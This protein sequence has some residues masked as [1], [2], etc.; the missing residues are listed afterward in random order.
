MTFR[1]PALLMAGLI[2]C[3]F[4]VAAQPLSSGD[5]IAAAF[6]GNT[7]QGSL[8]A[9]GK[10]EEFYDPSGAIRGSDYSGTWGVSGNQLCLSYDGD[11]P[12]CWSISLSGQRA[13]WIGRNGEEGSGAILKGNPRGY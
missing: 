4:P 3:G 8:A 6:S 12:S 11:P 9:S 7:V 1:P 13:V 10:F 2:L 5:E